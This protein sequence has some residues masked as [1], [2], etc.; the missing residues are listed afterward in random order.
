MNDTQTWVNELRLVKA[1]LSEDYDWERWAREGGDP[2]EEVWKRCH[3][4][5][6]L[7]EVYGTRGKWHACGS[8]AFSDT[9]KALYRT[10]WLCE[11]NHVD[12]SDMYKGPLLAVATPDKRFLAVFELFKYEASLYFYAPRETVQDTGPGFVE[13]GWPG[14]DNGW[15]CTDPTGQLF[16]DV[17]KE[18]LEYCHCVYGG[19]NFEV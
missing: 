7:E 12:F 14:A 1:M 16:F 19:N 15:R 18:L 6:G 10:L 9:P 8:Y 2:I 13:A 4:L 5:V 11:P 17:L 3:V